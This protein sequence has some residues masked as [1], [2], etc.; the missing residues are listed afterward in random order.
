MRFP[1]L[2]KPSKSTVKIGLVT[3]A[4]V[5]SGALIGGGIIAASWVAGGAATAGTLGAGAVVG[6]PAGVAGTAVGLA[7][8]GGSAAIAAGYAKTEYEKQNLEKMIRNTQGGELKGTTSKK[9]IRKKKVNS[10]ASSLAKFK[11]SNRHSAPPKV[12]SSQPQ[13]FTPGFANQK[14][15][16]KKGSSKVSNPQVKKDAKSNSQRKKSI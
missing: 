14:S 16:Q 1:K 7:I 9:P 13:S 2:K 12:P 11:S 8:I 15:L 4:I 5:G 6:L 10:L 3:S